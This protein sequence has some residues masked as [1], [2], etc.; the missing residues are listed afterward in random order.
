MDNQFNQPLASLSPSN[1]QAI[2]GQYIVVFKNQAS[3]MSASQDLKA[4]KVSALRIREDVLAKAKLKASEVQQVYEGAVSG[5]AAKLSAEQVNELRRNPNVAYVE[6]DRIIALSPSWKDTG[7]ATKGGGKGSTDTTTKGGGKGNGKGQTDPTPTEPAPTDSTTT[8]PAPT[9][10]A[11]ADSTVTDPTPTDSTSIEPTPT[12]PAA[13]YAAITPLE[14]ETVAWNIE[15]VGYGDGTGK[16]VWIID[17][18]VDTDHPDLNVDVARSYSF[19]YG[20]P[21]IEDGYGHGTSV[22][23]IVAAK[24]NGSGMIGV[25]ANATVVALRV[26]DD[27]GAGSVSRAISAVNYVINNAK[28]GD[29]VNMSLGSGISTTLDQAV[30][31]AAAKGI[32][33]SLAAGNSNVDCSGTSPARV[34]APGVYTISAMDSYNALWASSNFGAGVDF[35]APGVGVTATTKNGSIAGG[36]YGTSMATPHVAGI[37][38]LRGEVLSQ[39]YVTGDK[40]T[41]PDPIASLD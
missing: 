28:A 35:A 26:F 21:S 19:I 1:G 20:N 31:D 10:P 33:F 11:P 34:N 29:V 41:T 5:F 36:M 6:Q 38:L 9:E 25:A 18:G 23:G 37:L 7:I 4:S 15:R 12:E 27:A 24:N 2:E 17:S 32:L 22:A 30:Q 3:Q 39:G 8:A 40:D 13:A 16:T 14:G